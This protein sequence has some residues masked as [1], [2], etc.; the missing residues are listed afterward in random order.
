MQVEAVPHPAQRRARRALRGLHNRGLP[1]KTS[2]STREDDATGTR[3]TFGWRCWGWSV[4]EV[5]PSGDSRRR[6]EGRSQGRRCRGNCGC[7]A[8]EG[9][10]AGEDVALSPA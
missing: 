9:S 2:Q 3:D 5:W 7:H 4:S 8:L 1:R 6:L 10:R